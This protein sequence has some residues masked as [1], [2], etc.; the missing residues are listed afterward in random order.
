M[1]E[2]TSNVEFAHQIQENGHRRKPSSDRREQWVEIVEAVVLA[3]VA[4]ATAWSGYQAAKWDAISNEQ[5]N[6]ASSVTVRSQEKMTLA[7]QDRLYDITTFNGWVAAKISSKK[8]LAAFYQ[9]RFR[10]EYATAFSAW[11]K[12]DPVN[13]PSA[14]PGPIFMAEYLNANG[15]EA[16]R[17]TN[18]A[19]DHFE[20]GVS[21]RDIGD[22]YVKV[23]VFLA[24]VLLLT[25]LGQ[26]FEILGPRV[27]VVAVAFVLLAMS[28][29]SILSLP[30]A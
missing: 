20:K 18:Q 14:P 2:A 9:R 6:L 29:Y 19:K 22:R 7:G 23:T 27:A 10:P 8:K 16:A 11:W 25:A 28:A 5:Y 4:V 13:N 1:S 21:S 26:R 30:R 17:L 15:Q 3:I 24:T 12:L